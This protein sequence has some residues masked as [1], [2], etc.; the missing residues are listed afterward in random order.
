VPHPI[1]I[2]GEL[3]ADGTFRTLVGPFNAAAIT[4]HPQN[5]AGVS[6]ATFGYYHDDEPIL[7]PYTGELE[8]DPVYTVA[9]LPDGTPWLVSSHADW[10]WQ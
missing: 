7:H 5:V 9:T 2:V 6:D 4:P 8:G 1:A 3:D 10:R